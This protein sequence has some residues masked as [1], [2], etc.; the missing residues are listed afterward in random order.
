METS[1]VTKKPQSI[2]PVESITTNEPTV[3]VAQS[4]RCHPRH[5][6]TIQFDPNQTNT[7]RLYSG[8]GGGDRR[9]EGND[10]KKK[11]RTKYSTT[12]YKHDDDADDDDGDGDD[13]NYKYVRGYA[14]ADALLLIE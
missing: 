1:V 10:D 5:N 9:E 6:D 11:D 7:I 13:D 12:Q 3:V 14:G 8:G 4:N 2:L